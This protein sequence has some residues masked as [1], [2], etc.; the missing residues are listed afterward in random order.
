[1]IG[2]WLL[3]WR[4]VNRKEHYPKSLRDFRDLATAV[5]AAWERGEERKL[6]GLLAEIRQWA[7]K[8]SGFRTALRDAGYLSEARQKSQR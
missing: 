6:V 1:M 7:D 4:R 8:G 2:E 5:N 3:A